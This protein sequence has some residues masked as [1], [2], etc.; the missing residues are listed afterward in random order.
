MKVWVKGEG[1]K[2]LSSMDELMLSSDTNFSRAEISPLRDARSCCSCHS[3]SAESAQ[4]K[5]ASG[6]GS[7]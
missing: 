1:G 7:Y 5:L 2:E 4:S 3:L 6:K